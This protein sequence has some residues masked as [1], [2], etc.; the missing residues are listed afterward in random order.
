[1]SVDTSLIKLQTKNVV[2]SDSRNKSGR[3]SFE[4]NEW[5]TSGRTILKRTKREY[6]GRRVSPRLKTSSKILWTG[7]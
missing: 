4:E 5:E 1:V 6:D 7:E 2:S 3:K